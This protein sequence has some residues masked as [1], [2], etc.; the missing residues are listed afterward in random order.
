VQQR[1]FPTLFT[2]GDEMPDEL[3]AHLRY[4][5]DLFRIQSDI[6]RLYHVTDAGDFFSNVDPWQIA[7]DPSTSPRTPLRNTFVDDQGQPYRPMLPYYLLMR[8]PDDQNQSF[9]LMQPFTPRNRPNMV[10]FLVAKSDPGEYGEIVDY[11]FPTDTAQPG[12]GQVGDFINQDTEISA[13][14]TL[15]GQG[16]SEVIQGNMLVVPIEESLLYVQPIYV[17]ASSGGASG[18]SG[19]PEVKRVVV[20]FNGQIE[21]RETL[22]EALAAIFGLPTESGTPG[23]PGEPFDGTVA[24]QVAQ[25]VDEANQAFVAADLALREGDLA[26]YAQS[27]AIAEEKIRE[28][29]ELISAAVAEVTEETAEVSG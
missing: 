10:S 23:E 16:G 6:Y 20:S 13:Q 18:S 24:E 17:N 11:T 9:I 29:N 21:M 4:P 27:I 12:P 15:L 3:R 8:L 19:I 1:I 7:I 28:A 14:F 25:L 26:A 5:E 22:G 2:P